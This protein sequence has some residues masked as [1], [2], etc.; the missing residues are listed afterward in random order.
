MYVSTDLLIWN[1]AH[2][3]SR[4]RTH[5]TVAARGGTPLMSMSV[6]ALSVSQ[7]QKLLG[8]ERT[9]SHEPPPTQ[10]FRQYPARTP[11]DLQGMFSSSRPEGDTG[12]RGTPHCEVIRNSHRQHEAD[13]P[14][15]GGNP[16]VRDLMAA[17]T[18]T[19][20]WRERRCRRHRLVSLCH[21]PSRYGR[22]WFHRQ[23]EGT[24]PQ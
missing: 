14:R 20:S 5:Q 19:N 21:S 9:M 6:S 23:E 10:A 24:C 17:Q 16:A 11:H 4:A 18:R 15:M 13:H 7:S 22:R 3:E 8:E 2:M 12:L 1:D